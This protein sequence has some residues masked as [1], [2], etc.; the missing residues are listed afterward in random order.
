MEVNQSVAGDTVVEASRFKLHGSPSVIQRGPPATG[1]HNIEV[2]TEVLGYDDEKLADV[3][4][5]LC[6]E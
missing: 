1:E 6:M 2:L 4:S 5:S 3:L